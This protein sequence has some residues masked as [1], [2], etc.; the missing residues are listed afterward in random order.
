MP[1]LR[2]RSLVI[3]SERRPRRPW[4]VR[5]CQMCRA[6]SPTDRGHSAPTHE[7]YTHC[8]EGLVLWLTCLARQIAARC[9]G[10]QGVGW[11]R[12]V[13]ARGDERRRVGGG[14]GAGGHK[15]EMREA[16]RG[17]VGESGVPTERIRGSAWALG[18]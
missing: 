10:A 11:G 4:G 2:L 6:Q 1:P 9:V 7:Q 14:G 12:P 15:H 16:G 18:F 8:A 5:S 17:E 3:S 13:G